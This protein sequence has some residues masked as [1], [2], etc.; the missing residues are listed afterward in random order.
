MNLSS[1]KI[2][3]TIGRPFIRAYKHL[4]QLGRDLREVKRYLKAFLRQV[5]SAD[6]IATSHKI[7]AEAFLDQRQSFSGVFDLDKLLDPTAFPRVFCTAQMHGLPNLLKNQ[8]LF[9]LE[10]DLYDQLNCDFTLVWRYMDLY[11]V[12]G[13]VKYA[14]AKPLVFAEDAFL[15]SILTDA[16]AGKKRY[17]ISVA[18]FLDDL[19]WHYDSTRASRL[20]QLL[21]TVD[22]T[23]QEVARGAAIRRR[24]VEGRL[25]KYNHQ[26]LDSRSLGRSG[27]KKILVIDQSYRDFSVLK[28]RGTEVTFR[29]M[30]NAALEEHPE[31]DILVKKHPDAVARANQ[32]LH[33]TSYYHDLP[34]HERLLPINVNLN[35]FTMLEEVDA[36]YTCSSQMGFEAVM[37][38]HETH[39]FG[40]PAYAGWG[41]TKDRQKS[42]RRTRQRTIDEMVYIIYVLYTRYAGPE[43]QK[44]E[45]ERAIDHLMELREEYFKR[46]P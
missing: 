22:L 27:R 21:E 36:V 9:G 5:E 45:A 31:A 42:P 33:Q 19:T 17:R 24:L 3:E 4:N 25:T 20:E 40:L 37:A 2:L 30:L 14:P 32:R 1:P 13:V 23:P 10:A 7:E 46:K 11:R 35:P 18:F 29:A 39:V 43:G 8:E 28:S 6:L 12:L 26:P 44:W 16:A 34:A 41:V 38:G 15:K